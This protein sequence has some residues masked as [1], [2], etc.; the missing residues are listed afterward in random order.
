MY[1]VLDMAAAIYVEIPGGSCLHVSGKVVV[2][3]F[4]SGFLAG[5]GENSKECGGKT[6]AY[7]KWENEGIGRGERRKPACSIFSQYDCT[8]RV[9]GCPLNCL[10]W[11]ITKLYT[12]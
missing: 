9:T 3:Q 4:L 1:F 12:Q 5:L 7:E 11:D 10:G 6:K 8:N 2:N